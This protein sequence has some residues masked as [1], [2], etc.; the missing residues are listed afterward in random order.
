MI[1][2]QKNVFVCLVEETKGS[3]YFIY[4]HYLDH[5]KNLEF[6][7]KMEF[8]FFPLGFSDSENFS[9]DCYL[10]GIGFLWIVFFAGC[11]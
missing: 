11:I 6:Q 1:N 7:Q 9:L 4:H 2:T 8:F 5:E 3:R 10:F